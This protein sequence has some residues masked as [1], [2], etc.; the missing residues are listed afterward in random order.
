M[1]SFLSGKILAKEKNSLLVLTDGG[2]GYEVKIVPPLLLK[3]KVGEDIKL[4]TYFHVREDCQELYGLET[5][6]ELN[7]FKML[8]SVNGVGPRS[9]LHILALGSISEI[10]AAISR[11]DID[12]LTKVSG[13]GKKIAERITMEL[14]DKMGEEEKGTAGARLGDVVEA[15]TEMG[16][17]LTQAREALKQIKEKADVSVVLKEALK[18]LNKRG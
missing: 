6:E 15:L 13:I 7:F 11:R 10:K 1:I 18:I 8:L 16:Y 12:F 17:T 3:V 4:F 9:V 2:I 14:K 5:V